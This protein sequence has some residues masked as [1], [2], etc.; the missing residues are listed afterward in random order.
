[1]NDE[2][3]P[4]DATLFS[5]GYECLKPAE[6]LERAELLDAKVIDV[7]AR[8]QRC[9][10]GFGKRQLAALLG[11]RYEWHGDTLG[12]LGAKIAPAA[13]DALA[14]RAESERL[15]LMCCEHAPGECHRHHTILEPLIAR[16]VMGWHLF[17]DELISAA[18]IARVCALPDDADDSCECYYWREIADAIGSTP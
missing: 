12:G 8:P 15:L 18:E 13:L 10:A 4:R 17:G 5:V 14:K 16:G 9:K 11:E 1:M 6:L 3:D 7:R 2:P